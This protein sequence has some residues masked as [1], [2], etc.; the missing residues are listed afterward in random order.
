MPCYPKKRITQ[1]R[2]T[3]PMF[4]PIRLTQR[5]LTQAPDGTPVAATKRSADSHRFARDLM[6][7]ETTSAAHNEKHPQPR[8][9]NSECDQ[10][11][12]EPPTKGL[13]EVR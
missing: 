9:S 13:K 8:S 4:Q 11:R 10:G 1:R 5:R 3:T 6:S 12:P 2:I 7:V